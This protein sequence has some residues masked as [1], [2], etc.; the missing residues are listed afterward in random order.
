MSKNINEENRII[1]L[2]RA[3]LAELRQKGNAFPNDF[4]RQHFST[5]LQEAYGDCTKESLDLQN[6]RTAVTGRVILRRLMGKASFITLQDMSGQIQ[7]YIRQDR[8]G[9][10]ILRRFQTLGY[11]RHHRRHRYRDAHQQGRVVCQRE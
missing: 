2:R 5:E 4:R 11:W 3:Y 10:D 1:A 8:I 9:K 6:I 7:L